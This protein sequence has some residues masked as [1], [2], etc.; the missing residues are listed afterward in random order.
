MVALADFLT[1]LTAINSIDIV[2]EYCTAAER[3][4][5]GNCYVELMSWVLCPTSTR[6][7]LTPNLYSEIKPDDAPVKGKKGKGKGSKDKKKAS[8]GEMPEKRKH[9]IDELKVC[10]LLYTLHYTELSL[11]RFWVK[12]M[13]CSM[14]FL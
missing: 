3:P 7:A 14:F 8:P 2:H 5:F 10:R 6:P 9:R 1:L 4:W 12:S 11:G 13:L